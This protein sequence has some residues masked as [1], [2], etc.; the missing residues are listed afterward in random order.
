MYFGGTRREIDDRTSE[1]KN[2]DLILKCSVCA[3]QTTNMISR[4][5]I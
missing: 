2:Y 3:D 5:E 1:K 4:E